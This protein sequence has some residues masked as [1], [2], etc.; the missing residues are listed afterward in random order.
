MGAY[1]YAGVTNRYYVF[2]DWPAWIRRGYL[3]FV[4]PSGSFY[5]YA[6]ANMSLLRR[7]CL[8]YRRVILDMIPSYVTIH[9]TSSGGVLKPV[10]YSGL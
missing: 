10:N 4:L 9:V 3:D 6:S 7:S 5:E 2:Q 1:F 8:F